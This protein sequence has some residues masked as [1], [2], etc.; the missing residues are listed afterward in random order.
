[1]ILIY[2]Q[3]LGCCFIEWS[4]FWICPIVYPWLAF[5]R[6][7]LCTSNWVILRGNISN[8]PVVG[9]FNHS[10]TTRWKGTIFFFVILN[11]LWVMLLDWN[12]L[13]S[14][15]LS[16][17]DFSQTLKT[18]AWINYYT[19]VENCWL[20]NSIIPSTFSSWHSSTK[21]SLSLSSS[22]LCRL[23]F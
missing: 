14:Y 23:Y 20:S 5:W 18:V 21:K 11:D 16:P 10:V 7:R 13:F 6:G 12:I 1:M 8:Y 19:E 17:R 3:S 2:L 15:N 4:T 9:K 22:S